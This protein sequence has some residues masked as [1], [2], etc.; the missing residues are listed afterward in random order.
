MAKKIVTFYNVDAAV[1]QGAS[2]QPDDVAL[3][4]FFLRRIGDAPDNVVPSLAALAISTVPGPDLNAAIVDFQKELKRRGAS[5]A[6]DGKVNPAK[7]IGH[8]VTSAITGTQYTIA[9]LNGTY[10]RRFLQFHDD[11]TKDPKCPSVLAAKLAV[12]LT[13]Y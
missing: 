5:T 6:V 3:V 10:R 13:G 12:P 7:S 8:G 9:H 4:R 1:G 11:I 2:N